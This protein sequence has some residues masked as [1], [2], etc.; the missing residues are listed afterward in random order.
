MRFVIAAIAMIALLAPVA[1]AVLSSNGR[2]SNCCAPADPQHDRRMHRGPETHQ[3][4]LSEGTASD[5]A[6]RHHADG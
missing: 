6:E 2:V 4:D 1:W 3:K 5:V